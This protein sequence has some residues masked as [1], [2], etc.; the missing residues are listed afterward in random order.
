MPKKSNKRRGE[1]ELDMSDEK[2]DPMEVMN[3]EDEE[4]DGDINPKI[5]KKK[6]L[7]IEGEDVDDPDD[8]KDPLDTEDDDWDFDEE[9]DEGD[10]W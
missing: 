8:L 3:E 1:E 9:F 5:L 6:G 4:V 7:H 2:K 10:K